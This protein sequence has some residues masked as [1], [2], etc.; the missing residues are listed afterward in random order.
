M[1]GDHQKD[2]PTYILYCSPYQE[3]VGLK[4]TDLT[5]MSSPKRP[6]PI[7]R[8]ALA[9]GSRMPGSY[10]GRRRSSNFSLHLTLR[11]PQIA[12]LMGHYAFLNVALQVT[13]SATDT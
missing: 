1:I 7:V 10:L 13:M 11:I 2:G 5:I 4:R 3:R 9:G 6:S 12:I 8:I